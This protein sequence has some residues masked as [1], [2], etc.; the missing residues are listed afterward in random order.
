MLYLYLFRVACYI[1]AC[2]IY[3]G[4]TVQDIPLYLQK[5]SSLTKHLHLYTR[6]FPKA[7]G[8]RYFELHPTRI[9]EVNPKI[10][11]LMMSMVCGV[12]LD[13]KP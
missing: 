3:S 11:Q 10:Y 9:N 12:E 5:L 4:S 2:F 8:P 7:I 13:T 6:C 1:F